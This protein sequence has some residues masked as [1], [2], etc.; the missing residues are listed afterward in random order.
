[1]T[2]TRWIHTIGT[3][4]LVCGC[5][6]HRDR[7]SDTLWPEPRPLGSEFSAHDSRPATAE[8]GDAPNAEASGA[9]TATAAPI[10]RANVAH[11]PRLPQAEGPSAPDVEGRPLALRRA[12][13]LALLGNP[14]FHA[15]S[16]E[17]RAAEARRVQAGLWPN[18]EL[19]VEVEEAFG[20]RNGLHESNIVV[21][22]G[23][24]IAL[25]GRI[26]KQERVAKFERNMAGW[27]YEAKRLD[28]L[29]QTARAFVAVLAAQ[30]KVALTQGTVRT[31][32]AVARTAS[33]RVKG[34][35]ASP[36]EETRAK[37]ALAAARTELVREREDL[38][39]A[40]I[41]LAAT[42][43]A[44]DATFA[45][46]V[47]EL[48]VDLALPSLSE[49]S[50]RLA[51]NPD[52]MRAA[53][54]IMQRQ[55]AVDLEKAK[56]IPDITLEA[57]YQRIEESN[58]D[59]F[60]AGISIPLPIFDRNQGGVRE[61]RA[62]LSKA[63]WEQQELRVRVR[64]ALAESYS[65]LA[66]AVHQRRAFRSEILPG[67]ESAFQAISEG[68]RQGTFDYMEVLNTQQSL[69]G[70]RKEYL[71]VL[72]ALHNARIDVERLIGESLS[73]VDTPAQTHEEKP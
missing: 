8:Q 61:A 12:M 62:S 44:T 65:K 41:R 46:A 1:M 11:E 6:S 63:R 9:R 37:V 33:D 26:G 58:E 27:D 39:V 14:G 43:G 48:D 24:A 22:I 53:V 5:A 17:V 38:Q 31:A 18:P 70:A 2:A 21:S 55:A 19:G 60:V 72:S 42:W 66:T 49:V 47:G 34:G 28:V 23:Q 15:S 56:R 45:E 30:R 36:V 4:L 52:V 25:G 59:A 50:S 40:R 7:A 10:P 13:A 69:A 32:E 64:T 35:A 71:E 54:A 57:G 29:T 68:Y 73:Q 51:R 20:D 16:W 67:S 3:V